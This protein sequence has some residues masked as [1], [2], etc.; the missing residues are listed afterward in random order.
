MVID[1]NYTYS[2]YFVM[3]T[4]IKPLC[5]TPESNIILFVNYTSIKK[6]LSRKEKLL[7]EK[8]NILT[9]E[10]HQPTTKIKK[11]YTYHISM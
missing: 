8:C 5:C 9:N 10:I 6:K 11:M 2:D 3:Y 4:N 7:Q 1:V